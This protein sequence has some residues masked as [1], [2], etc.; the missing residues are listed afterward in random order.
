M[1]FSN[2]YMR[3]TLLVVVFFLFKLRFQFCAHRL[4]KR[5]GTVVKEHLNLTDPSRLQKRP[6]LLFT[7]RSLLSWVTCEQPPPSFNQEIIGHIQPLMPRTP[8]R[9]MSALHQKRPATPEGQGRA[10]RVEI[11]PDLSRKR[12]CPWQT[13]SRVIKVAAGSLS[14]RAGTLTR[15]GSLRQPE[16]H[17]TAWVLKG[18]AVGD[19]FLGFFPASEKQITGSEK[20]DSRFLNETF[21]REVN[22]ITSVAL[23]LQTQGGY[24]HPAVPWQR[25]GSQGDGCKGALPRTWEQAEV[26]GPLHRSAGRCP[27]S[28]GSIDSRGVSGRLSLLLLRDKS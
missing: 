5:K 20:S 22:S 8:G 28:C 12:P 21:R 23:E 24:G 10:S 15:V 4:Y 3:N 18:N 11:A 26:P 14:G 19:R 1:L 16:T 9:K 6:S 7:A 25:L 2:G 13:A 27:G 17:P